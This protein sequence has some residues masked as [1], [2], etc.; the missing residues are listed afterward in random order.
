MRMYIYKA[1]D[2]RRYT[3]GNFLFTILLVSEAILYGY[4][5]IVN[6]CTTYASSCTYVIFLCIGLCDNKNN[7]ITVNDQS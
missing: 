5:Q 4:L 1:L 3:Y 2:L 7:A 6:V